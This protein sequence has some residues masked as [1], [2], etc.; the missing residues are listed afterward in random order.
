MIIVRVSGGL[1]NQLFQVAT[2]RALSTIHQQPLV[3]DDRGFQADGFRKFCLPLFMVDILLPADSMAVQQI[4]PPSRKRW[5]AFLKWRLTHGRSLRYIREKSLDFN[6][7]ILNAGPHCYLHGYWQ[8]QQYFQ[9]A[10]HQIRR[11]LTLRVGP[12]GENPEWLKKITSGVSVSVHVR[13]GDYVLDPKASRVHGTCSVEYY[14]AAAAEIA[15]RISDT[16]TFFVFS[17][18]P[19]WVRE[20]LHLPFPTQYMSHNDDHHNYE[21]LRL[22]AA[23]SHH[24]I[25]NSSFS[26][27]GAWLGGNPDRIVIAPKT[28]FNDPSRSDRSLVPAEW[29]RL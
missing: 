28:W 1:G 27:W 21:D 25:A 13:R 5:V 15:G 23:C 17:D 2:G 7:E 19:R 18:D 26:W 6:P 10:A 22:M 8:S 12:T 29:V 3:I 4:L 14:R 20:N 9:H 11:D 24:I 16:P